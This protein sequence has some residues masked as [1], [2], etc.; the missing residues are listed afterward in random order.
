MR[1]RISNNQFS[2]RV[3]LGTERADFFLVIDHYLA[4]ELVRGI[5]VATDLKN[6]RWLDR[7]DRVMRAVNLFITG[8]SKHAKELIHDIFSWDAL[9]AALKTKRGAFALLIG[10]YVNFLVLLRLN[11][12]GQLSL[13]YMKHVIR[14]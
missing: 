1:Y 12:L 4:Q 2:A 6:Y 10:M 7:R 11:K 5:L 13:S 8:Y 14:K 9:I 3:R